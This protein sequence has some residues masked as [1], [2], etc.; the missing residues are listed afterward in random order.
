[1]QL[2]QCL[3]VA[4]KLW[5]SQISESVFSFCFL[6]WGFWAVLPKAIVVGISPS[7]PTAAFIFAWIS[8]HCSHCLLNLWAFFLFF[9]FFFYF[10]HSS[11]LN[12]SLVLRVTLQIH[13]SNISSYRT[14]CIW[15]TR[16]KNCFCSACMAL[17]LLWVVWWAFFFFFLES[18]L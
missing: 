14:S 13:G 2:L 4:A 16:Q 12:A 6:S 5:S 17:V 11:L 18:F 10:N 9:F 15:S 7:L 3:C 1:M 8:Q